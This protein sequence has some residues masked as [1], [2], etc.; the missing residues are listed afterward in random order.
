MMNTRF[1]ATVS[2]TVSHFTVLKVVYSISGKILFEETR[3]SQQIGVC[4]D[5]CYGRKLPDY[6]QDCGV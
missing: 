2:I 3:A 1:I 6:R 4:M 5:V